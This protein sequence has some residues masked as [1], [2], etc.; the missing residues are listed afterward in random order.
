[1]NF[2]VGGKRRSRKSYGKK[3]K[4]GRRKSARRSSG[5]RK[6][7]R[8]RSGRRRSA[9]R[10]SGR[11]R[12]ARHLRG[13]NQSADSKQRLDQEARPAVKAERIGATVSRQAGVRWGGEVT[14]ELFVDFHKDGTTPNPLKQIT[15]GNLILKNNMKLTMAYYLTDK[16][17]VRQQ[18]IYDLPKSGT[19]MGMGGWNGRLYLTNVGDIIKEREIGGDRVGFV[20]SF[21]VKNANK[22]WVEVGRLLGSSSYEDQYYVVPLPIIDQNLTPQQI[23][24]KWLESKEGVV[25]IKR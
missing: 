13:G 11:R 18:N 10:R 20:G 14:F 16:Q 5:R 6:S 2:Q 9:R 3:R 25:K 15:L 8:R 4:S 17:G 19:M 23:H 7:A 22:K 21:R 24:E 1:M 12:S